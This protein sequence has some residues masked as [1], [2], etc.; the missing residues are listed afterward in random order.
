[1]LHQ[2]VICYNLSANLYLLLLPKTLVHLNDMPPMPRK[3]A[4]FMK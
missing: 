3:T 4:H 2:K 1:M